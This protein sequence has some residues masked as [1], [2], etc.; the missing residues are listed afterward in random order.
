MKVEELKFNHIVKTNTKTRLA[1]YCRVSTNKDDQLNS[2][3]SQIK[4][5]TDYIKKN[6]QY[7][8]VDIYAD[9]GISGTNIKKR[10]EFNRLLEDC[11]KKKIDRIITKSTSRFA[12]NTKDFLVSIRLLKELGISIYF[13]DQGIDT[14]KID[15]EMF[16]TFPGLISQQESESISQNVLWSYQKRMRSGEYIASRTPY[17]YTNKNGELIINEKEADVVHR[18]Y[19]LYLSGIGKQRIA[20]ILNEEKVPFRFNKNRWHMSTISYILNNEKYIGDAIFQKW[21]TTD[22]FPHEHKINNGERAKYYVENHH[23][24]IISKEQFNAVRALQKQKETNIGKRHTYPLSRK[25]ICTDCGKTFRRQ[26]VNGKAYWLCSSR[27]SGKTNCAPLRISESAVYEAFN[28]MVSK[29]KNYRKEIITPTIK[30]LQALQEKA[31]ESQSKLSEINRLIANYA[32]QNH[33]L[34]KLHTKGILDNIS[35]NE[36]SASVNDKIIKLKTERRRILNENAENETLD[37]LRKLNDL[38]SEYE[39]TAEFDETLFESIVD[40]ITLISNK[41]IKFTLLG[42]LNITEEV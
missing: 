4:Y 11:K 41:K 16:A 19:D 15:M 6:P 21:Y 25:I 9:E 12:R 8:L 20:N 26:I 23:T 37:E 40:K 35:Y 32:A 29:L 28:L 18:I 10:S 30:Y 36:Q 7:E 33:T 22:T 14:N 1:A 13:E 3:A 38:I 27:A 39:Q 31:N 17:G 5:Y 2:F 24:P 34:A 42:G